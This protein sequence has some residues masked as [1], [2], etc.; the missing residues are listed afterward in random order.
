MTLAH[1]QS[2]RRQYELYGLST[3]EIARRS[4]Q[5]VEVVRWFLRLAYRE[6][7]DGPTWA[8]QLRSPNAESQ[9]K[10]GPYRRRDTGGRDRT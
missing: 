8:E 10:L 5:P 4:G 6:P 2:V 3:S 9:A 1:A 7:G